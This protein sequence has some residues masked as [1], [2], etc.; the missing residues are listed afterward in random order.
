MAR[1]FTFL[2]GELRILQRSIEQASIQQRTC[3]ADEQ[4][5]S[6]MKQ[7]LSGSKA[8]TGPRV[9]ETGL[10]MLLDSA[11]AMSSGSRVFSANF[12]LWTAMSVA[13]RMSM[14]QCEYMKSPL[15]ILSS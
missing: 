9:A 8:R 13:P 15:K 5:A 10:A 6:V 11:S 1:F 2:Y 12:L 3:H 14:I 4:E 7:V